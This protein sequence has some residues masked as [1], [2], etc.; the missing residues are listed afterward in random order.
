MD[1]LSQNFS[2]EIQHPP[3][4][5]FLMYV[6]DELTPKETQEWQSHLGAC[7]SC[8]VRVAKIEETIADIVEFKDTVSQ[9][10]ISRPDHTWSNLD[11]RFREVD[12]ENGLGVRSKF[13]LETALN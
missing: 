8:R 5:E 9:I 4:D 13:D 10:Q 3:Q 12:A 7:W 1:N 6:D 11:G 2:A